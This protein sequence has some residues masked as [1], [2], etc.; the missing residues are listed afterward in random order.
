MVLDKLTVELEISLAYEPILGLPQEI[1]D[2]GLVGFD[3][4]FK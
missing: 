3:T 1:V 4:L 2:V